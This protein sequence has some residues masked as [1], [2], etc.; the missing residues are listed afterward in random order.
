MAVSWSGYVISTTLCFSLLFIYSF[1]FIQVNFL[2]KTWFEVSILDFGSE[3][4]W[5]TV[6]W[7]CVVEVGI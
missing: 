7:M 4:K 5:K 6:V 2:P 3:P 1:I